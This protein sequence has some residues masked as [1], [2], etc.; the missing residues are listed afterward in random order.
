MKT[1]PKKRLSNFVNLPN[2][3][4]NK[5]KAQY[6]DSQ[7]SEVR[8]YKLNFLKFSRE[9]AHLFSRLQDCI[10]RIPQKIP[11]FHRGVK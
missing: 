5:K 7:A 4:T 3:C 11:S 2:L 8:A 6:S 10:P 9:R 1:Y